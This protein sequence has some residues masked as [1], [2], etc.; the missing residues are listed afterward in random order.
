MIIG[1]KKQQE[2]LKK[3]IEHGKIPHALFFCGEQGLGK[4]IVAIEFIKLLNC[5]FP[6]NGEPCMT[7]RT[8]REIEKNIYPEL[9]FV[10]VGDGEKEI[11]VAQ[12]RALRSHLV[13]RSFDGSFKTIIIDNAELL[14]QEAQ[15]AFLKL[16][17]EPRGK[18]VFILIA[19]HSDALLSTILSRVQVLR[20]Y[21]VPKQEIKKF[22]MGKKLSENQA[23]SITAFSWG[24][25]GRAINFL[26]DP[27]EFEKEK[28]KVKEI[29]QLINADLAFRFQYAKNI[30]EKEELQDILDLWLRY[31][32][33]LLLGKFKVADSKLKIKYSLS[34][35]EKIVGSI[36]D[37]RYL[38]SSTN[39]NAKIALEMLMLEL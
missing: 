10:E 34:Q 24:R 23:T 30:S 1:H 22:L 29:T 38:L 5:R 32:R 37:I 8:C 25:P 28:Q 18:T 11:K 35:L 16:L 13:L 21:S 20:F 39:V 14:N 19:E 17:E 6:L 12:I 33:A 27:K 15:N 3:T 2:L 9:T 26:E 36:I 31:F 7:C 4:K